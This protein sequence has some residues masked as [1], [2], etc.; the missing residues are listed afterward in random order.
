MKCKHCKSALIEHEGKD[1]ALHCNACGCCFLKDGETLRPGHPQCTAA[2]TLEQPETA[3]WEILTPSTGSAEPETSVPPTE[4]TF[5]EVAP[6]DAPQ[7]ERRTRR[8]S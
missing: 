7:P 8:K 1:G 3:V 6:E 5:E 4:T 2:P